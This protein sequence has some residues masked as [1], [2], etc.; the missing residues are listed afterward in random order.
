[1][2]CCSCGECVC[3]TIGIVLAASGFAL[4]ALGVACVAA[5]DS[6]ESWYTL[7]LGAFGVGGV[8]CILFM[9]YTCFA[10]KRRYKLFGC[11]GKGQTETAKTMTFRKRKSDD[12][13]YVLDP[14]PDPTVIG[15]V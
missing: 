5:F 9:L 8:V 15:M 1:M 2:G 10:M 11:C 6:T 13:P 4:I 14:R 7:G 3:H 12:S